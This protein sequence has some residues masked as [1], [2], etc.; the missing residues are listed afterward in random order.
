MKPKDDVFAPLRSRNIPA[1]IGRVI[2][3]DEITFIYD[4]RRRLHSSPAARHRNPCRQVSFG[5]SLRSEFGTRRRKVC[6]P[7]LVAEIDAFCSS[8]VLAVPPILALSSMLMAS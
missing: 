4:R 1:V 8:F 6:S 5:L 2:F 7:L 3:S